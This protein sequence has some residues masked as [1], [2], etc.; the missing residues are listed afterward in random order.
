VLNRVR[1]IVSKGSVYAPT[2]AFVCALSVI[3]L[4]AAQ[5][6]QQRREMSQMRFDAQVPHVGA[7]VPAL[8]TATVGGD[9]ITLGG[10]PAGRRQVVFFFTTTCVY[11]KESMPAWKEIAERV[12]RES[13]GRDTVV[14]VALDSVSL[15]APYIQ[16][17]GVNFPVTHF[18]DDRLMRVFSARAVPFTVV[19]DGSGRVQYARARAIT[20]PAAIDS[21]VKAAR[22]PASTPTV[23]STR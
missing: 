2:A 4:L 21:V 12:Q 18:P 1:M 15:A 22:P 8:R 14:G 20:A 23:A 10:A 19:I 13:G 11:C 3:A 17:H 5:G 9:S 16:Q 6:R 7:W